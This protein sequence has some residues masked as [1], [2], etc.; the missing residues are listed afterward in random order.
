[1]TSADPQPDRSSRRR[2]LTAGVVTVLVIAVLVAIGSGQ[3]W[4]NGG[5]TSASASPDASVPGVVPADQGVVAEGRAVPIKAIELQAAVPGTVAVLPVAEGDTV[6]QGQV[7]LALDAS[8]ANAQAAQAQAGVDAATAG[9]AQ[10]KAAFRQAQAGVA[11][12]QAAVSEATAAVRVADAGRDALPGAASDD[13]E[14]QADAQ[15]DQAEAALSRARASRTQARA[16]VDAARAS[17]NAAEA[18]LARA[19]ASL[20]AATAALADTEIRAPFAGTVV[21]IEP[22]LGDQVAPG[23][24]LV[25][26]A[27][28]SAWRFETSD[29]SETSIAR[30]Q[31]GAAASITVD[32]L[33]G[34]EI[35]GT[36]E[37]VGGYGTSV[38]GDITFRVVVA[39]TGDVPAGLRW[40][41]TVTIEIEGAPA[42]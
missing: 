28:L 10:A 42:G 11:I 4:F 29:L 23:V 13:Q 5:A 2:G 6:T 34:E 17:V 21:S 32:G 1:M 12:A 8:A 24:A 27:D 40:N 38:Q 9:V 39:P 33:P 18:E 35:A 20:D 14:R 31:Q 16:Q 41:M 37:S 19:T 26:L 15:V 3:G 30:V 7:L 25:R 36:V 22:L